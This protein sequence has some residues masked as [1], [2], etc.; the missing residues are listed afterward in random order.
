MSEGVRYGEEIEW[1]DG[2]YVFRGSITD[3]MVDRAVKA[4]WAQDLYEHSAEETR[5]AMRDA[6][7]AALSASDAPDDAS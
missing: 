2:E 5:D 3:E 4:F 7:K 6:L 1:T